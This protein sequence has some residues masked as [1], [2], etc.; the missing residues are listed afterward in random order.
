MGRLGHIQ[1]TAAR[2]A[3]EESLVPCIPLWESGLLRHM[4]DILPNVGRQVR[5]SLEWQVQGANTYFRDKGQH[6]ERAW[7]M[8]DM[9]ETLALRSF[10]LWDIKI[11]AG[12]KVYLKGSLYKANVPFLI[13]LRI[14]DLE[15]IALSLSLSR[16]FYPLNKMN[17]M[18]T[19]AGHL[20]SKH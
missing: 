14:H 12:H 1:P 8:V 19:A 7:H 11:E 3:E 17:K 13:C 16:G 4:R 5:G 9:Q 2:Q 6:I 15:T 20:S 18:K 10:L